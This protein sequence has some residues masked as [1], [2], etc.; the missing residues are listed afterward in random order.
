MGSEYFAS[1]QISVYSSRARK[2]DLVILTAEAA[3]LEG[4]NQA[5]RFYRICCIQFWL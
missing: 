4:T 1:H 5:N 3:I 2:N